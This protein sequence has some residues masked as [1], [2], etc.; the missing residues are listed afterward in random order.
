MILICPPKKEQNRI[1]DEW[2]VCEGGA[3]NKLYDL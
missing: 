3:F 1:E 2:S